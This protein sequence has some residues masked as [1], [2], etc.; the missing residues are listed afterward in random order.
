MYTMK[1]RLHHHGSYVCMAMSVH[2]GTQL[3]VS[4]SGTDTQRTI[5][6]CIKA[7]LIYTQRLKYMPGSA[8]E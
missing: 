1:L 8:A 7:G 6:I 3:L 4:N 5:F 2:V